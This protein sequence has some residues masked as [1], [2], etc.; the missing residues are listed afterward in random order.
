MTASKL[1]TLHAII[2]RALAEGKS[3]VVGLLGTG[4]AYSGGAAALEET[5]A[6]AGGEA[7]TGTGAVETAAGGEAG[8]GEAGAATAEGIAEKAAL[9]ADTI[10]AVPADIPAAPSAV[11]TSPL[12]EGGLGDTGGGGRA[13]DSGAAGNASACVDA[14]TP[15]SP[16]SPSATA[17]TTVPALPDA[18]SPP[19]APA[20]ILRQLLR[21][22]LFPN[23]PADHPELAFWLRRVAAIPLPH[24]PLDQIM[25][26]MAKKGVPAVE[27]SGRQ[28]MHALITNRTLGL[29][30]DALG[31]EFNLPATQPRWLRSWPTMARKGRPPLSFRGGRCAQHR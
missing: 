23:L 16:P 30:I 20:A 2:D 9:G 21:S 29:Q 4:E 6:A 18:P 10:A 31:L 7:A 27:L 13:R 1:P 8:A 12:G 5:P 28:V 17:A 24:N 22:V 15:A 14:A 11:P 19:P 3:V 26:T 25:A